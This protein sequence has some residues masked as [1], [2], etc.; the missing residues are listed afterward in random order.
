MGDYCSAVLSRLS[1][2]FPWGAIDVEDAVAGVTKH[3]LEVTLGL[4]MAG[5]ILVAIDGSETSIRGEIEALRS[6]P[7][8]RF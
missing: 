8:P 3:G 4:D 5:N 7:A 6:F 1:S 2:C